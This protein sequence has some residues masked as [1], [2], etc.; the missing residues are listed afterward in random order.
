MVSR[1]RKGNKKTGPGHAKKKVHR[2]AH[3]VVD[4][5]P[6]PLSATVDGSPPVADEAHGQGGIANASAEGA[7]PIDFASDEEGQKLVAV[8]E[9]GINCWLATTTT[10]GRR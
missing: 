3:R 4:E 5:A 7:T 10:S 8:T 1:D 6:G 2:Q 9:D